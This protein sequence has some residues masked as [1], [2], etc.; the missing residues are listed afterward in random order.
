MFNPQYKLTD[1]IVA[2]LTAIAEAK[3]II[4]RAKLLPQQE[5]KLRRQALIRMTHSS[6]AIEGNILNVKQ[7]EDLYARQKVDAPSRDIHE[8]ENYIKTLRYISAAVERGDSIS[9]KLIL[10]IH[11]FVTAKTIPEDQSGYYRKGPVY[12]VRRGWGSRDEVVY[13]APE[14]KKIP[15]LVQGLVAWIKS[16]NKRKVDPVIA[17]GIVHA[18]VAAVHPFSDGN[19]RTARAL[20]TFILYERGYD[21]RRLFALEDYYNKNR[22]S[23][24]EAINMG[25]SY[26]E[27]QRDFTSWLEYFVEGFREEISSVRRKV[28]SLSKRKVNTQDDS[29]KIYL[30]EEQLQI[31][32]FLDQVGRITIKDVVDILRCPRRTAQLHLKRLKDIKMIKQVGKGPSS[33]YVLP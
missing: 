17:A 5:V 10:K 30:D 6:T 16:S 1:E 22:P 9:E 14:A 29:S 32:D 4:D 27:R 23:Y 15:Q 11:G 19:G 33:A 18:E 12:V 25:K 28:T 26:K 20:A 2:M 31:L 7:V 3:S 21:F 24:Y 13:T 8:V